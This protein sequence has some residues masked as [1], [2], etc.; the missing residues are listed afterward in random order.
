M[1]LRLDYKITDIEA[2]KLIVE[3]ICREHEDELNARNLETMSDYLINLINKDERKQKSILTQNRLATV[4]KR[5]TSFEGLTSKFENGEDGVYQLMRSDKNMILS[6][7]ISITK[8]DIERIPFIKQLRESIAFLRAIPVKNYIVQQAIVDLS[9]TQYLVKNAYNKPIQFNSLV[10]PQR[11]SIEWAD[12]L[13]FKN[14]N[15][16]AALLRNYS[17]LKT[18]S[19][20]EI[21]N[22]MCWILVDLE[23]VIERVLPRDYPMLYDILI[24]KVEE[25]HNVDVQ[26]MLEE[27]YGKTFSIE[28]ISSLF[29][30]KIPK[31]IAEE[32]EKEE[33]IW[34][35]TFID[36]G[37]WKKC[38]RCGQ[39]KLLHPKFFSKNSSSK[40]GFY[41]ICKCCRNKK[42][43]VE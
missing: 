21:E 27:R 33:L 39:I 35:Y 25:M 17:K 30:N 42:K 37:N 14:W 15:H 32:A 29:N 8:K 4:T 13:D 20:D 23:N 31:L 24:A 40:N 18:K 11:V 9:Q 3:K 2:R 12:Y 26:K 10:P 34:Y 6:P 16:V 5:E 38:N 43:G 19:A 22:D 36:Y 7:A 28:Y 41:S 1:N